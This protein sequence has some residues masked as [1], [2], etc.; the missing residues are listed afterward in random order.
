MI[1]DEELL[2]A[3]HHARNS[4]RIKDQPI[5]AH[6]QARGSVLCP[7]LS[8]SCLVIAVLKARGKRHQIQK[9]F[10]KCLAI[11]AELAV[12]QALHGELGVLDVPALLAVELNE[13]GAK[14]VILRRDCSHC[15]SLNSM[16]D[17]M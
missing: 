17:I 8:T 1:F 2:N 14:S 11:L 4:G 16:S 7:K 5:Q 13:P 6:A 12:L 9:C 10:T 3:R 15:T